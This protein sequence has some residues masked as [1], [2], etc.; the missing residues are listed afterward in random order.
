MSIKNRLYQNEPSSMLIFAQF[1]HIILIHSI[2]QSMI[3]GRK[4]AVITDLF[5]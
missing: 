3:M 1:S 2:E 5:F 4:N